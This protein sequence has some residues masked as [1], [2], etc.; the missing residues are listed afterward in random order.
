MNQLKGLQRSKF[1]TAAPTGQKVWVSGNGALGGTTHLLENGPTC[2][3]TETN[4]VAII[5]A[6]DVI[7][8]GSDAAAANRVI[9]LVVGG[10]K[11]SF[12]VRTVSGQI[13]QRTYRVRPK[14]TLVV[15]PS[16]AV[17]ATSDTAGHAGDIGIRYRLMSVTEAIA[18]GYYKGTP[19]CV[20]TGSLGGTSATDITG[21]TSADV[22]TSRGLEINGICITGGMSTATSAAPLEIMLEFYNGTTSRKIIKQIYTSSVPEVTNPIIISDCVIRGPIGYGLR[23]T[24]GLAGAGCQIALWGKY[25]TANVGGGTQTFP[26]TG[27]IPGASDAAD[28]GEHFWVFSEATATGVYEFFP[29]TTLSAN[30]SSYVLDGYSITA[31]GNG[32]ANA[33]IVTLAKADTLQSVTVPVTTGIGAGAGVGGVGTMVDDDCGLRFRLNDRIGF[34]VVN[35]IGTMTKTGMLAWGRLGSRSAVNEA[36]NT[37]VAKRFA[38]GSA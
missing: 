38:G 24:A 18:A 16:T 30:S 28:L 3:T 27:V 5:D 33:G 26:G 29:S 36:T 9:S 15:P 6:I 4:Q 32:A 13:R 21:F 23:V 22:T 31:S 12:V 37:N 8:T 25:T 11:L 10:T 14:G 17:S 34:G 35:A 7:T 19:W 1:S 2:F 20:S